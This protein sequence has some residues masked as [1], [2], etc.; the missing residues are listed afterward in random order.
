[1]SV[2]EQT[3]QETPKLFD[4]F[5]SYSSHDSNVATRLEEDLRQEGFE[6]W[7]DKREVLVGHNIVDRVSLGLSDSRFVILLLS[8]SSVQS[9]W[10]KSEWTAAYVTEI[11][12]KNVVILPALVEL[13]SIPTVL[14]GKKYADLT[15]WETGLQEIV[16]AMKG[17]SSAIAMRIQKPTH[18]RREII[19]E[20]THSPP[21]FLPGK[22]LAELLAGLFTGGVLFT[23]IPK[24]R[25]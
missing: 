13:C 8:S 4:A 2:N 22:P 11:E 10:V 3:P 5:I 6:V 18:V 15:N 7:L 19:S 21:V 14:R 24:T 12:S 9:E 23:G 25:M 17:H 1:M 16:S 20:P